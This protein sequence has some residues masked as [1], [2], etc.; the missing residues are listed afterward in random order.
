MRC[1]A[2]KR[3]EAVGTFLNISYGPVNDVLSVRVA[4]RRV[5]EELLADDRVIV[6]PG[7]AWCEAVGPV[8]A[9]VIELMQRDGWDW[10]AD[11]GAFFKAG[12]P[13]TFLDDAVVYLT[14]GE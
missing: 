7:S 14:D 3:D 13:E 8:A 4:P 2:S 9:W 1:L 12:E 10:D 6:T 11:A 5:V